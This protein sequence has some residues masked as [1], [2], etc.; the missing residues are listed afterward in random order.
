M[1]DF[2]TNLM[3]SAPTIFKIEIHVINLSGI[4]KE[5]DLYLR[6]LIG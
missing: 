2:I 1:H 6:H 5:V 4:L 3:L